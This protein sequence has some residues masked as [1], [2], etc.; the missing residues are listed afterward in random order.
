MK[1]LHDK[2]GT[3]TFGGFSSDDHGPDD[4]LEIPARSN[5]IPAFWSMFNLFYILEL[6]ANEKGCHIAYGCGY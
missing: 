2:K 1:Y 5:K 3:R 6:D 4:A